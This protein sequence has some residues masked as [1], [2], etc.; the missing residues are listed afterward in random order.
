LAVSL[1]RVEVAVDAVFGDLGRNFGIFLSLQLFA[2]GVEVG[3]TLRECA[4]SEEN[5]FPVREPTRRGNREWELE[6][7]FGFAAVGAENVE[8]GGFV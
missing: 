8:G 5:S 7:F 3:A 1:P 4:C 2:Q 6:D